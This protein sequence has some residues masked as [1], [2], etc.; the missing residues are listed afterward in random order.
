MASFVVFSS[1]VSLLLSNGK[2][3][4]YDS[5]GCLFYLDCLSLVSIMTL[6]HN[7]CS[8][9]RKYLPVSKGSDWFEEP[10]VIP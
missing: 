3:A 4:F 5:L 8:S 10:D 9:P 2:L 7:N 1:S 6:K